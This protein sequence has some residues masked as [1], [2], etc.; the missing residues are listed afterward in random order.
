MTT[1]NA[2]TAAHNRMTGPG[3]PQAAG[4]AQG[5]APLAP[6]HAMQTHA[7][8]IGSSGR[9]FI[10][11]NTADT[12]DA[13]GGLL[14]GFTGGTLADLR[15][16]VGDHFMGNGGNDFINAGEGN[17]V[18]EGGIGADTLFGGGGDDTIDGGFGQDVMDGGAGINTV[19]FATSTAAMKVNLVTGSAFGAG[20]DILLNFANVTGSGFDDTLIG[21]AAANLL[22]G[23]DGNDSLTGGDGDDTLSGGAGDDRLIDMTGL[24]SL[25]GGLG[26]D[27]FLLGAAMTGTLDG[28]GGADVLVLGGATASI[29]G[30]TITG[31]EEAQTF[32]ATVSGFASQFDALS[33][34][35]TDGTGTT[36]GLRV[37]LT[38]LATGLATTLDLSDALNAG[39]VVRGVQLTGS[40][41]AEVVTTGNGADLIY[42]G[43]GD[44]VLYG[45]GQDDRLYGGDGYDL[46]FGGSGSDAVQDDFVG[47]MAV[48]GGTGDDQVAVVQ[49]GRIIGFFDGGAGNDLLI[50]TDASDISGLTLSSVEVLSTFSNAI[51]GLA[52]QFN[53]FTTFLTRSPEPGER[54]TLTLLATGHATTLDLSTSLM[55]GN[56]Q[57]GVWLTTTSDDET[58]TTGAGGDTIW[59]GGGADVICSGA[60]GDQIMFTSV[61]A[62]WVDAGQGDDRVDLGSTPPRTGSVTGGD[63]FDT[64]TGGRDISALTAT[65]FEVLET[66]PGVSFRA[67]ADQLASFILIRAGDASAPDHEVDLTLASVGHDSVLDLTEALSHGDMAGPVVLIGSADS[68]TLTTA[69]GD[70]TVY[71]GRGND[72][73]S[74]GGGT[75]VLAGGDGDD[76]LVMGAGTLL[77]TFDGGAGTDEL[78]I[79]PMQ[80]LASADLTNLT[81]SGLETLR[82]GG[83]SVTARADQFAA[84]QTIAQASGT[85]SGAISL[86]LAATGGAT[87]LDL[88][89]VVSQT[90]ALSLTGSSDAEVLTSGAGDD[91][92]AGGAGNDVL[93][94]LS[95]DDVLAGDAGDD[96]LAGGAGN[97]HLFGGDGT[98]TLYGGSGDDTLTDRATGVTPLALHGGDGDDTVI[99]LGNGPLSGILSGGDGQDVLILTGQNTLSGASISG[100]ERLEATGT[101]TGLASQFASFSAILIQ[102]PVANAFP[103]IAAVGLGVTLLASG[104]ATTLDLSEALNFGG[105]PRSVALITSA[106]AET[107]TLGNGNDTVTAGGGDV[108]FTGGGNDEVTALSAGPLTI[109]TGEGDDTVTFSPLLNPSAILNG[110]GGTDTL[111]AS[112]SFAGV[113]L[114]EFE[115]LM[116]GGG[117]VTASAAQ[118]QDFAR[119]RV[120]LGLPDSPVAL[121]LAASGGATV[122]D[123]FQKL[124]VGQ[125][126]H[127]V[128][129]TGS[130]DDETLMTS[131]GDDTVDGGAGN[132]VLITSNGADL[133]IDHVGASLTVNAGHGNDT[134]DIAG[135]A[136]SSGRIDGGVGLN[137][138]IAGN[139]ALAQLK[140]ANLQ[141]LETGGGMVQAT[142]RQLESFIRIQSN[143]GPVMLTLAA[144]GATTRLDLSR[145]LNLLGPRSALLI[146]SD[147]AET[148]TTG[149]GNDSIGGGGGKDVLNG[150]IGADLLRGGAGADVLMGGAGNDSL[151]GDAGVDQEFGGAGADTFWLHPGKAYDAD[152]IRDFTPGQD[153]ILLSRSEFGDFDR[154]GGISLPASAWFVANASGVAGDSHDRFVYNTTTGKLS[155]DS[156]GAG[157]A[158]AQL[159]A[160]FTLIP[161]GA[162]PLTAA[163]FV[164]QDSASFG[165]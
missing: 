29:A 42:A 3:F 120:S 91:Q 21:N 2:S 132:D 134:I 86:I 101:Q 8:A 22:S 35:R 57:H 14:T 81:L 159:I 105:A 68:E 55:A 126:A 58:I 50:L 37:K 48:Y 87:T 94:G 135:T 102:P 110:G 11:G 143:L 130:A 25:D 117:A 39:A 24:V 158:A 114:T 41:D 20:S 165:F 155:F 83:A 131:A 99:V 40:A 69:G 154:P 127:G 32:G 123:L 45:G 96:L 100:F 128:T 141:V 7:L 82:T 151:T 157:G 98:D 137:T 145:E 5:G 64:L 113:S 138:L 65:G 59:G 140:L 67:T 44:D 133:I 107:I 139:A 1:S 160:G 103:G 92:V 161:T 73:L 28:G 43:Q 80:G 152:V 27:T 74:G 31:L 34:I 72:V 9:D 122:L 26:N 30:L 15:D 119:I 142:A 54:V 116:T 111:R 56:V 33:L 93:T 79:L 156:D 146:G 112:G 163:D 60:G 13:T 52:S 115:V 12:A 153:H 36:D 18:L 124:L 53:Q 106:D 38:L 118:M 149:A 62:V 104:L 144:I 66:A 129:L 46:Y 150:G 6:H 148:I 49:G 85:A 77:G 70:D 75:D 147:D 19:T 78:D 23:L 108:I 76:R 95:G 121:R 10:G 125:V 109:A 71:G 89:T 4:A 61:G 162:P 164:V 84:F 51:T 47:G 17:D 88:G 63:G 16:A 90:T 97:D 136:F